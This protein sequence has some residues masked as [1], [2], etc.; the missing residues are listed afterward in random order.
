[1]RGQRRTCS[2]E[3]SPG[4]DASR[5]EHVLGEGHLVA[6]EAD[7]MTGA[8]AAHHDAECAEAQG[9]DGKV[10]GPPGADAQE[11]QEVDA[12]E[13]RGVGNACRTGQRHAGSCLAKAG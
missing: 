5:W 8:K 11:E 2:D 1:M 10:T 3:P 6:V 7:E 9:A 4:P 13:G 12:G